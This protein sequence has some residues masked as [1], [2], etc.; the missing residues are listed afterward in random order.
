MYFQSR[1]AAGASLAAQITKKYG[2]SSCSVVAL[3]DGAVV[4]G[5]Q[6][7]LELRCPLMLLLTDSIE[8]PRENTAIGGIA[9]D[10]TFAYNSAYSTGE[11]DDLVSEY[12]GLIEQEKMNKMQNMHRLEGNGRLIRRDLL[13]NHTVIVVSDGLNSGFP[14]D[15]A[16]DY[17]KTIKVKK[18]VMATPMA[19]V[20]AVDRM[21][22]LAD[23][24][25]CLSVIEDYISTDHYYE[26]SDVPQHATII[27][28]IEEIV[29]H[30]Q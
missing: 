16:A 2:H 29:R 17:L 9:Q 22:I 8:L 25:Y 7:A 3:N 6:I 12:H 28:T 27:K 30:W 5:A 15:L 24:I 4:V 26:E 19:N 10:G 18:L 23:E 1:A 14:I 20:A 11:I 21:H 13:R